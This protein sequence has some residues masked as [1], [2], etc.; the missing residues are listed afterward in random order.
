VID[1][2][3]YQRTLKWLLEQEMNRTG[4]YYQVI[5]IADGMKKF[6]RI[7]NVIGG[8]AT[9]GK[10][11]IGPEHSVFAS[12]F[13]S[14]GPTYAGIDDDLDASALA[15]QELHNPF[16]ERTDPKTGELRDDNVEEFPFQRVCP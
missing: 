12:Q 9:A 1:A 7:T 2:V 8:L 15:L 3:A 13:A 10:L 4:V 16:L 5:P 6:S 14:F 11:W